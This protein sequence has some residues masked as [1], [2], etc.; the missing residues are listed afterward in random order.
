MLSTIHAPHRCSGLYHF[1]TCPSNPASLLRLCVCVGPSLYYVEGCV[2]VGE[3]AS[4]IHTTPS[5]C[6][7]HPVHAHLEKKWR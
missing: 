2:C 7:P 6:S 1:N 5:A 3:R 4:C